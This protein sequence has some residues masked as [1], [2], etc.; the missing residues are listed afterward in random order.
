MSFSKIL[1]YPS[2]E[3]NSKWL[4]GIL[5]LFDRVVR[6]I[7]K[8]I[9]YTPSQGISEIL[10]LFPDAL[11][12]IHPTK[13]DIEMKDT[14]LQRMEKMFKFVSEKKKLEREKIEAYIFK[15]SEISFKDHVFLHPEKVS[16]EVFD[17][18][19]KYGLMLFNGENPFESYGIS[20]ESLIVNEKAS[21]LILSC[22]A[23]RM[24]KRYGLNTITDQSLG[25]TFS[26]LNAFDIQSGTPNGMLASSI[27]KIM[28]PEEIC[29]VDIDKYG[30]IREKYSEL[31]PLFHKTILE[32]SDL[33]R[34][35]YINDSSELKERI[36]EATKDFSEEFEEFQKS[37]FQ[38]QVK[39]W[40]PISLGGLFSI[41]GAVAGST[42]LVGCSTTASVAIQIIQEVALSK[43]R[44]KDIF[45]LLSGLRKDI[46]KTTDVSKFV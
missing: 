2:F 1:Y 30:E 18:L 14:E 45:R 38:R 37:K 9:D 25:F 42:L 27:F 4:R 36:N 32:L 16:E 28:I 34:L 46:L 43:G 8:D 41:F 29:F 10:D 15:N 19:K 39:R 3:P 33:S 12:D 44:E 7:P 31:R 22:L 24:S 6:I 35:E 21:N 17:L 23:D 20:I 13:Y 26:S 11:K 5:L 40:I